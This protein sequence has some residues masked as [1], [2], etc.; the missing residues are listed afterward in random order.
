MQA[1][2]HPFL[3]LT[4]SM[5][6]GIRTAM[7]PRRGKRPAALPVTFFWENPPSRTP[8]GIVVRVLRG[9]EYERRVGPRDLL[10]VHE[11][12]AALD[13]RHAFSIYRLVW[14]GRLKAVE[15]RGEVIIPLVAVA[16]YRAARQRRRG[17]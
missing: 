3:D 15:R 10:D 4:R 8:H 16:Q 13:I 5:V 12:A 9:A 14:E 7:A 1:R 11:A 6:G 2:S 17:G